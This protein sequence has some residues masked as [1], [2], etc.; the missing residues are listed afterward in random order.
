MCDAVMSLAFIESMNLHVQ[1][2]ISVN[3]K[4]AGVFTLADKLR[5][6][7]AAAVSKLKR[8]GYTIHLLSGK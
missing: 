4:L 7:S 2:Y 3:G 8:Q 5:P 6:D 1:M